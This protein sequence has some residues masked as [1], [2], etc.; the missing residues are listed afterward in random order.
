MKKKILI[1]GSSGQIGSYLYSFLKKRNFSPIKFDILNSKS[2]DLRI[3]NNY[4]LV[5]LLKTVD[6][7]FFLAFDVGGSKY[8]HKFQDSSDFISNNLLIMQNTF[9]LLKKYKIKFIFSSTQM[10]NMSFSNYGIL[11]SIGEKYTK[12]IGGICVKLWNVYGIEKNDQKSHVITD[13]IL[14]GF[15][16]NK[17]KMLTNGK[18]KR[19]FL[20]VEDCCDAFLILMNR[21]SFFVKKKHNIDI[22][23]LYPVSIL[24]IAKII[25]K[26]FLSNNKRVF[27]LPSKKKDTI[28]KSFNNEP[29]N[30]FSQYWRPKITLERGIEHIFNYHYKNFIKKNGIKK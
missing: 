1:L 26:L 23:F 6:F 5:R 20:H 14:K 29:S 3:I 27:F 16:S 13:F 19:N 4:K 17:V 30:F 22:S 25:K 15:A 12:S 7:V 8:L 11:K 2:E 24:F 21:Y 28:Q 10:A 9:Q 18:E